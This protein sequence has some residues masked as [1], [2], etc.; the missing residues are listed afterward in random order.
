MDRSRVAVASLGGTIAM[1]PSGE[2]GQVKPTLT[3]D[4]L[5]SAV[6]ELKAVAEI[7]AT[8]LASMPGASLSF[9]HV[10]GVL[11]WAETVLSQGADGAVLV[12][13]TDTIEETSYLLDLHW[14]HPEPLV[15]T[16]AMRPPK[17]PGADGPANLLAAV[18]TAGSWASRGRGVLVVMN[19]EVHD[20]ARVR[21]MEAAGVAAFQSPKLGPVGHVTEG[22]ASYVNH[23][24]RPPSLRAPGTTSMPRV[25]LVEACFADGPGLLR[26]AVTDGYDGIVV[27]AF[28]AGHV[29]GDFAEAIS[30]ILKQVPVVFASRTGS[31]TTLSRTYGFPGSE[32]DLIAR[33]AVPA[34]WLDPRKARIL[35]W[36]LLANGA[37]RDVVV[38]EF[39]ERGAVHEDPA[40][41]RSTNTITKTAP[42]TRG[43]S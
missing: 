25:A 1:T 42:S 26:S 13:G 36:S 23:A 4:M 8:T 11:D 27:A 31:G 39:A 6:P 9:S 18:A 20:A 5:V 43:R 7:S 32:A 3:A 22:V 33:G 35:L 10:L 17:A 15:V 21:K 40:T 19:D 29:S 14:P 34:G 2:R 28:G 41:A 38:K 12:Q 24:A 30:E 16:G 37:K